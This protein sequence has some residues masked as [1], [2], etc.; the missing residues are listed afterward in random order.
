ML[1]LFPFCLFFEFFPFIYFWFWLINLLKHPIYKGGIHVITGDTGGGKTLLAHMLTKGFKNKGRFIYSNSKFSP[2]VKKIN[3]LD[4]F[5]D[6]R[7]KKEIKNCILVLDE[8]SQ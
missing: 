6:F 1:V 3:I 8:I 2:N 5:G 4:Y 7:Q